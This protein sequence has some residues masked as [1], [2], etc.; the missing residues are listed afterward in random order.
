MGTL[1]KRAAEI[2]GTVNI[3]SAINEGVQIVLIFK[4]T[5]TGDCFTDKKVFPS[6][7]KICCLEIKI[8]IFEDNKLLRES[9]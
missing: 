2:S 5:W 4:I 1:K 8:V 6:Q 3:I 9:L 7:S